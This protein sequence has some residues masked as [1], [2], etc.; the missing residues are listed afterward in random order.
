[1]EFKF[2]YK[3]KRDIKPSKK[4]CKKLKFTTTCRYFRDMYVDIRTY[5]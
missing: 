4:N 5:I 2:S 3:L 1:M